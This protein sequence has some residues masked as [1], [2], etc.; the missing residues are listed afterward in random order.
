[1]EMHNPSHPGEVLKDVCLKAHNLTITEA[2][3]AL[4]VTRKALSEL[5]NGH[6]RLSLDMAM[7][8]SIVFGGTP[9]SWLRIQLQYDAWQLKKSKKKYKL[10]RLAA[11]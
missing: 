8:I 10:K 9:E 6:T 2:S 7:R 4:G 3:K 5:L 1:M 11:A